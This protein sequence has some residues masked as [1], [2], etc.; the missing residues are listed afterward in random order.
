MRVFTRFLRILS[1][2]TICVACSGGGS[3]DSPPNPAVTDN[4]SE[5]STAAA[6]PL[7]RSTFKVTLPN[8]NGASVETIEIPDGHPVYALLVSGFH[9]NRNFELF[10]FYNF[11]K[12]LFENDA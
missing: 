4:P 3:S 11:A 7:V 9:Q 1:L 12:C 6:N 8:S 10:H 2:T 5:V